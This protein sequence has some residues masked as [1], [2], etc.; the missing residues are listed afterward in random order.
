MILIDSREPRR[1]E[2]ALK[3]KKIKT[4]R[5]F[6]EVADYILDEGHAVERKDN[7]LMQSIKNNRIFDQIYN[8]QEYDNPI[9]MINVENLWKLFYECR[10]R[11]ADKQY[12]GFLTTLTKSFPDVRIIPY[13]GE[14]M[15]I[16]YMVSL[17]KKLSGEGKPKMR[18]APIL[19]KA[20]SLDERKENCLCGIK[21][22]S[23][24]KAQKLLDEF[25]TI[26]KISNATVEQLMNVDTIGKVLA[27]NIYDILH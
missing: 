10:S 22:I 19:R 2:D 4:K 15:L 20:K 26:N 3:K 7:D 9:L 27:N 11:Y 25:G 18:P 24:G 23:V 1:I 5:E 8:I 14:K 13:S 21:G 6:I 17:D 16:D 12:V